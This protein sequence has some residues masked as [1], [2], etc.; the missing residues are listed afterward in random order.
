MEFQ[1]SIWSHLQNET[2]RTL[3]KSSYPVCSTT[4]KELKRNDPK[5]RYRNNLT[6]V[7]RSL[8]IVKKY[9]KQHLSNIKHDYTQYYQFPSSKSEASIS[10]NEIF[11]CNFEHYDLYKHQ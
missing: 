7:I 3:S 1:I 4:K 8:W 9:L 11:T 6:K 2:E 10:R 5:S